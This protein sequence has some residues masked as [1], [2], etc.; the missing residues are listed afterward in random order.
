MMSKDITNNVLRR[1]INVNLQFL[2]ASTSQYMVS[3]H[4]QNHL[5]NFFCLN[6]V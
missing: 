6:S 5:I 2:L 4:P 1:L 3:I